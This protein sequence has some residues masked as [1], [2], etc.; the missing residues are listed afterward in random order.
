VIDRTYQGVRPEAGT[1]KPV[2]THVAR[3]D[4]ANEPQH[5]KILQELK[6]NFPDVTLWVWDDAN[7]YDTNDGS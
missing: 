4:P 1:Y 7:I 6:F 5:R 2:V 3:V